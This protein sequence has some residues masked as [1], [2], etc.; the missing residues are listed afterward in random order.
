MET[1][2]RE[3]RPRQSFSKQFKAEAVDLVRQPGNTP[4]NV[5]RDLDLTDHGTSLGGPSRHRR[6]RARRADQ[7]RTG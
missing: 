7:R 5:T 1:V 2:G 6:G 4:V 3:K